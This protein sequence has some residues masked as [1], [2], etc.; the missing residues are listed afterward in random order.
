MSLYS[1][2]LQDHHLSPSQTHSGAPR[3]ISSSLAMES[4]DEL[5][6]FLLI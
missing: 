3:P 6:Q 5:P 1:L 2:S 4:H